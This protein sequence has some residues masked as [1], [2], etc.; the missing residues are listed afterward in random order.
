MG[1]NMQP[2][3]ESISPEF[4]REGPTLGEQTLCQPSC[5]LASALF[6]TKYRNQLRGCFL[7]VVADQHVLEKPVVLDFTPRHVEATLDRGFV[8]ARASAQ[9]LLQNAHA[10]GQNE[11][12][13][14]VRLGTFDLAR[15]LVV[16]VEDDPAQVLVA[17]EFA[18]AGAV[19]V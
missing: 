10:R 7:E 4:A 2:E 18:L 12:G 8:L 13:D 19:E 14:G 17:N 16:D 1:L 11:D 5:A 6:R 9:S 15:P 3:A